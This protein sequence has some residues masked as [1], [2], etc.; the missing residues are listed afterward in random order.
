MLAHRFFTFCGWS[1]LLTLLLTTAGSAA[2]PNILTPE[3]QSDGW[4]LLFDGS[5]MFGWRPAGDADW[6]VADGAIQVS[7]G[8]NCLLRTTTQFGNYILKVDFRA[9][10]E[11]NSGIFLRTSPQPQ[12]VRADCYE[13][14]IAPPANPFPTASFVQRQKADVDAVAPDVW[15][16]F[17]VRAEDGEFTVQLDGQ[18]VLEYSDPQPLGR[19]FIGLQH[20]AGPAAFRNIKLKPLGLKPLFNGQDLTGWIDAPNQPSRFAVTE[21]GELSVRGGRGQLESEAHFAD[22]VL[23]ADCLTHAAGL[24]SGIFFRCVPGS[25]MDGYESQI[26]NGFQNGDRTQ[27]VDCGTGGIFRRQ[28]ARRVVADDGVWFRKTIIADG[29]H[30]AV[31]VNGYLVTDWTDT[32]AP[33]AN[34]RRGRRLEAGSI[35]V[36][37]H[38]PTT[39]LS[40]RRIEIAET[41]PRWTKP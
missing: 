39:D 35:M 6:K 13:L 7:R 30:I 9:A 14:N 3:E 36:Q 40:F 23:Q 10:A 17:E 26:H 15:H 32:R 24:N 18:I 28:N 25:P 2:E 37:A 27:P 8:E 38:D 12:N 31:W 22:F 5:T 21:T 34:P 1:F 4:L 33:D 19:G 29:P 11:T 41:P 16:S 20:N